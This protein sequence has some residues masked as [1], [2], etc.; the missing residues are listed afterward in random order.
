[1]QKENKQD[2]VM[3]GG[4][5]ALAG[6]SSNR[7]QSIEEMTFPA[8]VVLIFSCG[9][10]DKGFPLE[11]GVRVLLSEEHA[12]QVIAAF[13]KDLEARTIVCPCGREAEYYPKDVALSVLPEK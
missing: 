9:Q 6:G 13:S 10:C 3:A 11:N 12:R 2:F 4:L 1:M 7:R 5:E 8:T